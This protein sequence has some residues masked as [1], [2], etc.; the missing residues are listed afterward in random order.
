M[1]KYSFKSVES[2]GLSC[3]VVAFVACSVEQN[4]K[5]FKQLKMVIKGSDR[6]D[7][8]LAKEQKLPL[9]TK[10]SEVTRSQV[11]DL[12]HQMRS[13]DVVGCKYSARVSG[14]ARLIEFKLRSSHSTE[15]LSLNTQIGT[16]EILPGGRRRT[17][18]VEEEGKGG[19]GRND[20]GG[21][22]GGIEERAGPPARYGP[23]GLGWRTAE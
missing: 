1:S 21:H 10:G 5:G 3:P 20:Q 16:G 4:N 7:F 13:S 8:R 18:S 23:T 22:G 2:N 17:T 11:R 9:K 6:D 19:K 15:S 14:G 12:A